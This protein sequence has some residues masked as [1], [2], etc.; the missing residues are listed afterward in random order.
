MYKIGI[1][2]ATGFTGSELIKLLSDHNQVE[3]TYVGTSSKVGKAIYEVCPE[4]DKSF[5]LILEPAEVIFE[6]ELDIIFVALPHGAAMGYI[7]KLWETT[8]AKIIDLSADFRFKSKEVYEKWYIPHIATNLL[9]EAVYGLPETR[10]RE[11]IANG[12]LIA[13]P[14]CYVTAAT[15]AFKP[16]IAT[17]NFVEGSLIV[18][19]KSGYSGAGR[20]FLESFDPKYDLAKFSAY[21]IGEHRHQAE[22]IQNLKTEILFS[23]HLLPVFRGILATCYVTLKEKITQ[24]EIESLYKQ[25]FASESFVKVVETPPNIVDVTNTNNA[26]IWLKYLEDSNR[27]VII[28]VIDNLIKGA[29][30]QA[31]QNMN[32][33]LGLPET[34]GLE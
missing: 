1:L 11:A 30:G 5:D 29:S 13:N 6:K 7:K 21:K 4:L 14:G 8:S 26:H 27:L 12:R 2:G 10:G 19:A 18:D 33:M 16:L 22:M 25:F 3:I 15:L 23:P 17:G 20:K 28:S 31:I 9:A 34:T 24:A 32:I